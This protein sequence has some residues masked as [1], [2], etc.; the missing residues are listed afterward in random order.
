[1]SKQEPTPNEE[2]HER[3]R[4]ELRKPIRDRY[5]SEDDL[6]SVIDTSSDNYDDYLRLEALMLGAR[7]YPDSVALIERRAIFYLDTEPGMFYSFME[8]YGKVESVM[9]DIL[10]LNML[11]GQ[12]QEKIIEAVE[13]FL[14]D[15]KFEEDEEVIQFVQTLVSLN[16][17]QWLVD[18]LDRLKKITPYLPSL[19]YEYAFSADDSPVI[20]KI[21]VKVLEELTEIEPYVADY[22]TRLALAHLRD[23]NPDQALA[24]IDYALAID[25]DNEPALRTK[26]HL[27]SVADDSRAFTEVVHHLHSLVPDDPEIAFMYVLAAESPEETAARIEELSPAARA[28]RTL[29]MRAIS[30][31]FPNLSHLLEE[32]YDAG[33]TDRSDWMQF[34]DYAYECENLFAISDIFR[35]FEKKSGEQIRHDMLMFRMMFDAGNYEL[36]VRIFTDAESGSSLREIENLFEG[37]TTFLVALLRLG[38]FEPA[39]AAANSL[40][41][42]VDGKTDI[43]LAA[44]MLERRAVRDYLLDILKRLRSKRP[45]DWSKFE[46]LY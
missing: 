2:L 31:N 38:E 24:A 1:M 27:H 25:P 29:L 16:L 34:A 20:A 3:F 41:E 6:I 11:D 44:S 36:V 42:L 13:D 5:F 32:V 21:S 7:L 26:L 23:D 4:A 17:D 45:T 35:I 12:P 14:H 43:D 9:M 10:R 46:P 39:R 28:S 40:L 33:I 30:L 8:D 15:F 19:L 22:W 37:Y 18:N